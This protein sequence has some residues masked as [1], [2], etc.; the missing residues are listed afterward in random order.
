MKCSGLQSAPVSW[1]IKK[2]SNIL[3]FHYLLLFIWC[4][5]KSVKRVYRKFKIEI[6]W[7]LKVMKQ[8]WRRPLHFIL[9]MPVAL[10]KKDSPVGVFLW[11][12]T[13]VN[14]KALLNNLKNIWTVNLETY[15][16]PCQTSKVEL[17][18]KMLNSFWLLTIFSKC[19][20]V[21]DLKSSEHT[22][23]I[24]L[25]VQLHTKWPKIS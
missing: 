3:L 9:L 4:W 17:F 2:Y 10:L 11:Y 15:S 12:W 1:Q 25:R 21:D 22:S 16:E 24:T 5:F 14:F 20:M 7:D 18:A 8:G 13:T 23:K 6:T 19:S